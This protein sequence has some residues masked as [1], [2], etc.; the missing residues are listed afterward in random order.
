[1]DIFGSPSAGGKQMGVNY[2]I[3][4]ILALKYFSKKDSVMKN[5]TLL[6]NIYMGGFY[7]A[8]ADSLRWSAMNISGSTSFF[9][10][11]TSVQMSA[12]YDPYILSKT[13]TRSNNLAIKNG[14]GLLRFDNASM[15]IYSVLTVGKIREILTGKPK[16]QSNSEKNATSIN[17]NAENGQTGITPSRTKETDF[18]SLFENFGINHNISFSFTRQKNGRDTLIVNTNSLSTRGSI[19]I[20]NK[21]SLQ[22]GNIGY[23]FKAKSLTYPDIGF[24][25]DL[26]CWEAGGSWQPTRGTYSFFIRV[27]P[28]ST[29]NFINLPYNKNNVDGLRGF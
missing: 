13:G 6:D 20:T 23:D 12:A 9:K 16:E 27:K 21:W 11:I 17:N 10:G 4:H 14:S 7:N 15:N 29:F 28:A 26:H 25:R 5:I 3:S 18:L 2:S 1:V 19:K 8:A 22:I 24:Y